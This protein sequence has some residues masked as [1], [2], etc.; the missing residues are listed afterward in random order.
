[1]GE[2]GKDSGVA[3]D[4]SQ[5]QKRSGR[6]NKDVGHQ[7]SF[8]LTDGHLSFEECWIGDKAPKIQ[9]SSCTPRWH[10]ERWFWFVYSFS[11][12]KVHLRPQMTAGK[13][14][15]IISRLPGYDGQA[16][17][18]V[19]DYTQVKMEDAPKFLKIPKSE[20]PD[21]WIRLPKHKWPKS[22][23]SMEDPVVRLERILYGHP[24]AGLKRE[25]QFG[26]ILL[27]YG[28]EK[29]PK[30][31]MFISEPRKGVFLICVNGWQKNW[32]GRN[33]IDPMWKVPMKEVD[34]G[35]PP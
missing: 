21:T 30:L 25:R 14:M 29:V 8:C 7:S 31:G 28:W 16:A 3:A 17:D 22:W 34:L 23:S 6:W 32:L 27:K 9:R 15:D 33:N 1:M 19:S 26:K 10:C 24:L 2:I 35:E 13:I 20:C 12:S 5:K 18:A 4:K 11:Q